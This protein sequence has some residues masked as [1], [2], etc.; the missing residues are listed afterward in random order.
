M[1]LNKWSAL[2]SIFDI[3]FGPA[4]AFIRPMAMN[5]RRRPDNRWKMPQRAADDLLRTVFDALG[6][7]VR[8]GSASPSP[9]FVFAVNTCHFGPVHIH[10]NVLPPPARNPPRQP[11]RTPKNHD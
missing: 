9:A 8:L 3:V 6:G 4:F 11:R 1:T 7:K 5:T 10:I 2:A